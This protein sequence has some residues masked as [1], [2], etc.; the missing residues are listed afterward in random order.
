M[1]EGLDTGLAMLFITLVAPLI[2]C[3]AALV[4]WVRIVSQ[5][6]SSGQRTFPKALWALTGSTCV[7]PIG[8]LVCWIIWTI[9]GLLAKPPGVGY[10]LPPQLWITVVVLGLTLS[11]TALVIAVRERNAARHT[12]LIGSIFV[13]AVYIFGFAWLLSTSKGLSMWSS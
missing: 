13:T 7:I 8:V 9:G 10:T 11:L 5:W 4:G 3:A 6:T 12:V 1:F 2:G